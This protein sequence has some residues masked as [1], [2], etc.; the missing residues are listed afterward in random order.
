MPPENKVHIKFLDHFDVKN[1][2]MVIPMEIIVIHL[3]HD[4]TMT[5]M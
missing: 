5:I 4:L 3:I 2:M 1:I